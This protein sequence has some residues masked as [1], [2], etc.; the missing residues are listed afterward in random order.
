VQTV[1]APVR[2]TVVQVKVSCQLPFKSQ[3]CTVLELMGLHCL[4]LGVQVV[5]APLIHAVVHAGPLFWKTPMVS[6]RTGW[7][8][9]HFFAPG[10]QSVQ[11][12]ATQAA[13]QAVPSTQLP[14]ASHVSGVWLLHC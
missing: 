1:H 5:H 11:L 7:F 3:V 13:E 4:A 9:L 6:Q 2:Q 8:A 12:P 14:V 10:L